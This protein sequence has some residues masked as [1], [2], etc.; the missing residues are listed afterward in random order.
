[1]ELKNKQDKESR[2]KT[3]TTPRNCSPSSVQPWPTMEE[4]LISPIHYQWVLTKRYKMGYKKLVSTSS[5]RTNQIS[6]HFS[7]LTNEKDTQW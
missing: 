2:E 6:T 3:T 7:N 1:M 5:Q 4:R